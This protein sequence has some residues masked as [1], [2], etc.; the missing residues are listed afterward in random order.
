MKRGAATK[1]KE[2]LKGKRKLEFCT[3]SKLSSVK[4]PLTGKSLYLDV[5]DS[6]T[7]RNLEENLKK[8]GATVEDFLSKDLNYLITSQPRPKDKDD[9]LHSPD[10]QAA[11]DTPSPFSCGVSPALTS[12]EPQKVVTVTRGKA[13][14]ERAKLKGSVSSVVQN[15]EKWGVKIVSLEA[16]VKWIEK[17]LKKLPKEKSAKHPSAKE[18]QRHEHGIK[19]KKLHSPFLKFEAVNQCY[20]PCHS[21]LEVWPRV[22][23]DTRKG[24]CPFDGAGLAQ[25]EPSRE[26]RGE[27]VEAAQLDAL[28]FASPKEEQEETHAGASTKISKD[29]THKF[30]GGRLI[31]SGELRRRKEQKRRQ[32]RKRGYCECCNIKYEDL[33]KH[34]QE[35]QHW[36]FARDKQN[37]TSLD[38]LISSAP[39]T[40][41]YL[42]KILMGHIQQIKVTRQP[43]SSE[44]DVDLIVENHE[45]ADD[46]QWSNDNLCRNAE[47]E[48]NQYGRSIRSPS[49]ENRRQNSALVTARAE[50]KIL[51]PV[52]SNRIDGREG[53]VYS[54]KRDKMLLTERR[55]SK[56]LAN[57]GLCG[58]IEEASMEL[59][60][61]PCLPE[62]T[63][64]N[65]K[66]EVDKAITNEKLES[67]DLSVI[68]NL[69][70]TNRHGPEND[71]KSICITRKNVSHKMSPEITNTALN[72][73]KP[74]LCE[75][76][77]KVTA[78]MHLHQSHFQNEDEEQHCTIALFSKKVLPASN[79]VILAKQNG[80]YS[81]SCT[82]MA[83]KKSK[84]VELSNICSDSKKMS[85]DEC[86][87]DEHQTI[88]HE[89]NDNCDEKNSE[90][91]VALIHE[92]KDWADNK[93]SS[94]GNLCRNAEANGNRYGRSIRSPR[95]E[96]KRQNSA[97]VTVRAEKK[98]SLPVC[99][100]SNRI[101]GREGNVAPDKRD[102]ISQTEGR[103]SKR[104]AN[105]GL[106]GATEEV[107]MKLEKGPCVLE[108]TESNSKADADKAIISEL[109]L[110]MES[111]ELSVIKNMSGNGKPGLEND[112]KSVCITR[113][114][115]G[116]KMPPNIT[117]TSLNSV[118]TP[119]SERQSKITA[120][121]RL[122]QS[123]FQEED[124]DDDCTLT[125]F[126]RRA[127]PKSNTTVTL[128]KE[129]Y[130][131][132]SLCT[133]R[134]SKKSK[135]VE[136]T[137]I[138]S[139]SKKMSQDECILDK[140]QTIHHENK[141]MKNSNKDI[142]CTKSHT[143]KSGHCNATK[144]KKGRQKVVNNGTE[145]PENGAHECEITN[146]VEESKYKTKLWSLIGQID[147]QIETMV[148]DE[149]TDSVS[150]LNYHTEMNSNQCEEEP[151]VTQ[152]CSRKRNGT[153]HQDKGNNADVHKNSQSNKD[154]HQDSRNDKNEGN[155]DNENYKIC[156]PE[157]NGREKKLAQKNKDDLT[158]NVTGNVVV[159]NEF[160]SNQNQSLES[161]RRQEKKVK[162]KDILKNTDDEIHNHETDGISGHKVH[163]KE[164]TE[165]KP[166]SGRDLKVNLREDRLI[167]DGKNEAG[168]TKVNE[169]LDDGSKKSD[170]LSTTKQNGEMSFDGNIVQNLNTESALEGKTQVARYSR[171]LKKEGLTQNK[172]SETQITKPNDDFGVKSLMNDGNCTLS[173]IEDKNKSARCG[174]ATSVLDDKF[175]LMD[176]NVSKSHFN[177]NGTIDT[178]KEIPDKIEVSPEMLIF[179]QSI[180]EMAKLR[181]Q[182]RSS[183]QTG[184]TNN[185]M[186]SQVSSFIVNAVSSDSKKK[187]SQHSK[188][189]SIH[190]KQRQ[191]KRSRL[192]S[193]R[194]N[195]C[196]AT[197]VEK[198][199]LSANKGEALELEMDMWNSRSMSSAK[200]ST[201][202]VRKIMKTDAA[203]R[204]CNMLALR[205]TSVKSNFKKLRSSKVTVLECVSSP[206][207]G[208][209]Y[210]SDAIS[211]KLP[212]S[213]DENV[214]GPSKWAKAEVSCQENRSQSPVFNKSPKLRHVRATRQLHAHDYYDTENLSDPV[215]HHVQTDLYKFSQ[216]KRPRSERF[217]TVKTQ[218]I[219]RDVKQNLGR[220]TEQCKGDRL[221]Q[222]KVLTPGKSREDEDVIS[223]PKSGFS[224]SP[225][226]ESLH[227]RSRPRAEYG[228]IVLSTGK[229]RSLPRSKK[230][231]SKSFSERIDE[232]EMEARQSLSHGI[233]C[234]D[235]NEL[236]A[237][238][239]GSWKS[240][241]GKRNKP[242]ADE[243][244]HET[245]CFTD[246]SF[247][248]QAQQISKKRK[249]DQFKFEIQGNKNIEGIQSARN[250]S[251]RS[252]KIKEC[253]IYQKKSSIV[254]GNKSLVGQ[255]SETV[256]NYKVTSQQSCDETSTRL[257]A[258]GKRGLNENVSNRTNAHCVSA[259]TNPSVSNNLSKGKEKDMSQNVSF[260]NED[261]KL[262]LKWSP[263][264]LNVTSNGKKKVKLKRHWSLLSK[265]SAQ[266]I[267]SEE[268]DR[269]SF[270]GFTEEE[271]SAKLSLHSDISFENCSEVSFDEKSHEEWVIDDE[272]KL[273][274]QKVSG[275]IM[276]FGQFLPATF[277]SPG[278]HSSSSWDDACE[279]YLNKSIQ[280]VTPLG[281][282]WLKSPHKSP[283]KLNSGLLISV[284]E[285]GSGLESSIFQTPRKDR[286]RKN[287][288]TLK[289]VPSVEKIDDDIEFNYLSPQKLQS[290][291]SLW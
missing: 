111:K 161:P 197:G 192:H 182:N 260:M 267:F 147:G 165:T 275:N 104:L 269:S 216:L 255:D 268:D 11:V 22:N 121:L 230:D 252:E 89:N 200:S 157:E 221:I 204:K 212:K 247:E 63:G 224:Y 256:V 27:L 174:L 150:L 232:S 50:E 201:D 35:Q 254:Q 278:K 32:E 162:G 67:K 48:G 138:C 259:A 16:T 112:N 159:C 64:S 205:K 277:S 44:E 194:N 120:K 87:V 142:L 62:E 137:N 167:V 262:P 253:D 172:D 10:S 199:E 115:V 2:G 217:A 61:G 185:D 209:F 23:T 18:N 60:K 81:S 79:T 280:H 19:I 49:L 244:K 6:R 234:A 84:I 131:Y 222:N 96:K 149:K 51:L 243:E 78:E 68:E 123:H 164:H 42:Q 240:F 83:S 28:I 75:R 80:A 245:Q 133:H 59:E 281:K 237:G 134:A 140:Y 219:E 169:E 274:T 102:E 39:S 210:E 124:D 284:P 249:L 223:S 271:V 251:S 14:A 55:K 110:Q 38:T 176:F 265:R 272:E 160:V 208:K 148:A 40:A 276:D 155:I 270:T 187:I 135:P 100:N 206:R 91:F 41:E 144:K 72:S 45:G 47:A 152:K 184:E 190:T 43:E 279:D 129:N 264:G 235:N 257:V 94:N 21:Q 166:L 288:S 263:A 76:Q 56:R 53:N 173:K 126:S 191:N 163:P 30:G 69:S 25:D 226:L 88:H 98:A 99:L 168:I 13:I 196:T 181:R 31:T 4:L 151:S 290:N 220:L 127:L 97:L 195:M 1:H 116:H 12:A 286:S 266:A 33:D 26:E 229:N 186:I 101:D 227:G 261:R 246:R 183:L 180:A 34:V 130:S 202:C 158:L 179:R 189:R 136:L 113:K 106:C 24:T 178:F 3:N 213:L 285:N 248:I 36:S 250:N 139:D 153:L 37:F 57:S 215:I 141:D 236:T 114:N 65:S 128:A 203:K 119:V 143:A 177:A 109:S 118:E 15:A 74:P 207:K 9:N 225:R 17:E 85:E 175:E 8:F 211:T 58:T 283:G 146:N 73:A 125:L 103:K 193:G 218:E 171:S 132:S 145:E 54:D 198:V 105:S 92:N 93:Q 289:E 287:I 7:R 122:Q 241:E 154:A 228:K 239:T 117:N 52:A 273:E 231:L 282:F 82:F 46:E 29:A 238:S 20:R 242:D 5:K 156:F 188:H 233:I 95:L 170:Y 71:S 258:L 70:S 291:F 107:S 214:H 108:D 86:I 66:V 90:K 77:S